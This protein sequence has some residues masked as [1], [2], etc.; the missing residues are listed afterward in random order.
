MKC[1]FCNL[2]ELGDSN[3]PVLFENNLFS[4]AVGKGTLKPGY[5]LLIPKRHVNSFAELNDD[6]MANYLKLMQEVKI[7][8]D[9]KF[10]QIPM[11]WENGSAQ[12]NAG[13]FFEN[14]IDH[15]HLH[16]LPHKLSQRAFEK[17]NV[18]RHLKP[19]DITKGELQNYRDSYYLLYTD[20]QERAF[21]SRTQDPERQY[22]RKIVAEQE[23]IPRAWNWREA[24]HLENGI[25]TL[26]QLREPFRRMQE[27][28]K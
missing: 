25:I 21:I 9:E 26:E 16:I 23:Q 13:G 28:V 20:P 4:I 17:I 6:E 18:D 11:T 14:S 10:D 3:F 12:Q 2:P 24:N 27:I 1:K 8:Y 15:A 19:V 7:I 22:I 5:L